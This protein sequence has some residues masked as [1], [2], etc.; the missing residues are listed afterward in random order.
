MTSRYN[1]PDCF[2]ISMRYRRNMQSSFST[3]HAESSTTQLD[4]QNATKIS[5]KCGEMQNEI[6]SRYFIIRLNYK[7]SDPPCLLFVFEL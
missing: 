3:I 4:S 6:D 2:A 1:T 5:A 7:N